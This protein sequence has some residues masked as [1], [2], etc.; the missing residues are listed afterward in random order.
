MIKNSL[1][2]LQEKIG[3]MFSFLPLHPNHITV[4]SLACAAFGAYF[5]YEKNIFGLVLFLFAFLFDGLDGAIARAK[6]LSS[7][8]GA[9]LDGIC[10][11]LVEFFALLPFFFYPEFVFPSLLALFFGTCMHSF[12]KAYADHRLVCDAKT[13][14]GLKSFLPRTERVIGIFLALLL[15]V[16]GEIS[17]AWYLLWALAA[18]SIIAFL[19]LQFEIVKIAK[20]KKE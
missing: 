5:V 3:K 17:F 8:F 1:A 9:Y 2:G 15:L 4:L 16:I 11:R 10:D 13:A 7:A 18:L 6:S 19:M 12:S 20:A 14:A